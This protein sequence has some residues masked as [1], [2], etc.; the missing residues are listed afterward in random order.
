LRRFSSASL[1]FARYRR[2]RD[3]A[4]IERRIDLNASE[5]EIALRGIPFL[6]AIAYWRRTVN[7]DAPHLRA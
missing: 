7:V 4:E 2:G 1:L 3:R 5:N 6:S